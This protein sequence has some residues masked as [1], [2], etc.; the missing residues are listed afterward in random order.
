MS[1]LNYGIKSILAWVISRK[2][3]SSH[4]VE[5]RRLCNGHVRRNRTLFRLLSWA[6]ESPLMTC[7]CQEPC[8][9]SHPMTQSKWRLWTMRCTPWRTKWSFH[10]LAGRENPMRTVN[11]GTL[12]G[13]RC[14]LT[15]PAALGKWRVC[16]WDYKNWMLA[17][18]GSTG[19]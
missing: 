7:P 2:K 10:T 11:R 17:G 12:N 4:S 8:G 15:Q 3:P 16:F 1:V 6:L 19:L 9:I 14:S 5:S 13:S 18:L